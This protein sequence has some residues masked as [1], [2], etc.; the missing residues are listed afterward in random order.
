MFPLWHGKVA[1]PSLPSTGITAPC[2]RFGMV[3][4]QQMCITGEELLPF[5]FPLW[6]GKVATLCGKA[7]VEV[8]FLF[9]L[10]HGKVATGVGGCGYPPEVGVSAL[11]W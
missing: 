11:A 7:C 5:E 4:L 2:F 6:H 1:T 3:K 10:W 8:G 9:P